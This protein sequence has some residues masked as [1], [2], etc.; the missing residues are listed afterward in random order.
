LRGPSR[1]SQSELL[2][3]TS[4]LLNPSLEGLPESPGSFSLFDNEI[5][6]SE[7][8]LYDT[9]E[10]QVDFVSDSFP[11]QFPRDLQR[12][13]RTH[14]GVE[15]GLSNHRKELDQ[16]PRNLFGEGGD[17]FFD[18]AGHWKNVG[19]IPD[20]QVPSLPVELECVYFGGFQ[21]ILWCTFQV[22]VVEL[23][24]LEQEDGFL[25]VVGVEVHGVWVL[26]D[27]AASPADSSV[28][29]WLDPC[30]L[31][32]IEKTLVQEDSG[33]VGDKGI[34]PPAAATSI[35]HQHIVGDYGTDSSSS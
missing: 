5:F 19:N 11:S 31:V 30:Y 4:L 7:F 32:A 6:S 1:H 24:V 10:F 27:D 16:P 29:S 12:R 34:F 15:D 18:A 23:A 17:S 3:N 2:H 35:F 26:E 33:R 22:A 21:N 13:S 14:K 9:F 20:G 28:A 8:S 25:D